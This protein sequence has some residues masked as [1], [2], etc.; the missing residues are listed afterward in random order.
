MGAFLKTKIPHAAFFLKKADMKHL[1]I[2]GIF[3][4]A[5]MFFFTLLGWFPDGVFALLVSLL[6]PVLIVWMV[7]AILKSGPEPK[8]L[9][10]KEEEDARMFYEYP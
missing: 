10:E 9:Q 5:I 7:I 8:P 3:S 1:H 6:I 2:V 4:V